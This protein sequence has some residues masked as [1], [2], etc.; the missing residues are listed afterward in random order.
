MKSKDEDYTD[1]LGTIA[2]K[3][4]RE[5]KYHKGQQKFSTFFLKIAISQQNPSAKIELTNLAKMYQEP[6]NF[7]QALDCYKILYFNDKASLQLMLNQMLYKAVEQNNLK[8]VNFM[9]KEG[10]DLAIKTS[11]SGIGSL[12]Y[13]DLLPS[14][15]PENGLLH[16]ACKKNYPQMVELLLSLGLALFDTNRFSKTPREINEVC[17]DQA[18]MQ[19]NSKANA[20]TIDAF[21]E[22]MNITKYAY[23]QLTEQAEKSLILNTIKDKYL[24]LLEKDSNESLIKSYTAISGYPDSPTIEDII[25]HAF[26]NMNRLNSAS[27]GM[28]SVENRTLRALKDLGWVCKGNSLS[29]YA[30]KQFKEAFDLLYPKDMPKNNS[31]F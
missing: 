28:F 13:P 18:W 31:W 20:N 12:I 3:R 16:L 8:N 17:F 25:I 14:M 27:L 10:A 4:Y 23:N 9:I 22:M 19:I 2:Y 6:G 24:E 26:K 30:P 7:K 1:F 29:A 11:A 15:M 5:E 21:C